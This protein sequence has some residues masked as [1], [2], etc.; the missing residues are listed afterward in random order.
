MLGQ[1][2][3][4]MA[5]QALAPGG[6][7]LFTSNSTILGND[8]SLAMTHALQAKIVQLPLEMAPRTMHIHPTRLV[9][10]RSQA[11]SQVFWC[12]LHNVQVGIQM[13]K[14]TTLQ[15]VQLVGA[16][17]TTK[18]PINQEVGAPPPSGFPHTMLSVKRV[19]HNMQLAFIEKFFS[20]YKI[21]NQCGDKILMFQGY[22]IQE[23]KL[24]V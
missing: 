17:S 15:L 12:N 8:A 7:R 4:K 2:C 6:G 11:K 3:E 5:T 21:R 18:G 9:W 19:K 16:K 14:L 1:I 10:V 22:V 13:A 20:N 24:L 23:Q